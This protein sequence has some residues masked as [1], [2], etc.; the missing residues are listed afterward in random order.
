MSNPSPAPGAVTPK[1]SVPLSNGYFVN[2]VAICDDGSR[3]L[4][5]TFFHD[6][7]TNPPPNPSVSPNGIFGVFC[8]D[9]SGTRLWNDSGQMYEGVYW[10]ALSGNGQVAAAGGWF[11]E[12]QGTQPPQGLLRAYDAGTGQKLLDYTAITER[13]SAVALSSNGS[14]LVAIAEN[15]STIY[16]FAQQNG[17]FNQT[18]ATIPLKGTI[19]QAIAVHPDGQW[20]VACDNAGTAYLVLT[21]DG[22]IGQTYQWQTPDSKQTFHSVAIGD[23]SNYFVAGGDDGK[24]YVFELNA[25]IQKPGP[26]AQATVSANAVIRW[27]AASGN[28]SWITAVLNLGSAGAL[29]ALTF[30]G[31]NLQSF[32][33]EP[34]KQ[35]PN[36]TSIDALGHYVAAADGFE[37]P[38]NFYL[39]DGPSG[40]LLWS[41]P[42]PE[43]NWPM[44]VSTDGS[45]IAAGSDDGKLY[46]FA[47]G[48]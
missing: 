28:A 5:G 10:V 26:V 3:V 19:P 14:L 43:M 25:M 29:A 30:D 22:Q 27:V 20:F 34:L 6:Y 1:W 24:V 4:A 2:S 38:G 21:P 39:F 37:G 46:Y 44:F 45:A 31:Q 23:Q 8:Y 16:V 15:T 9:S 11:A 7:M 32:W 33:Q 41:Y 36:C 47:T 40:L 35:K 13:V 12:G 42:T 48:S 18:P 17:V